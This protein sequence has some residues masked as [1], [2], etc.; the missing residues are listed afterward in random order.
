[1]G[2]GGGEEDADV[3]R[4]GPRYS[5]CVVKKSPPEALQD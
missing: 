3:S 5:E 4:V 1:M 2:A